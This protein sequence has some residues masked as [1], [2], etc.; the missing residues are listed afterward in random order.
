MQQIMPTHVIDMNESH[1][2]YKTN[3]CRLEHEYECVDSK[4]IFGKWSTEHGWMFYKKACPAMPRHF[5]R[6]TAPH[7]EATSRQGSVNPHGLAND[8]GP[9][10][11]SRKDKKAKT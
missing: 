11:E 4:V 9:E 10:P 7:L 5:K 3:R 1:P 6:V 2:R 8:R